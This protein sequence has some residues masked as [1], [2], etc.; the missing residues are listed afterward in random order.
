MLAFALAFV[1]AA[2]AAGPAAKAAAAYQT[3]APAQDA[4][5]YTHEAGGI[6][7][8]LPEGWKADPDDYSKL[9]KS[10]KKVG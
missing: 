1:L 9:V 6:T 4:K 3:A 8:D 2:A 5:T 7:F 10:I